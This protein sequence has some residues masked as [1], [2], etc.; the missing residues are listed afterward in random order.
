ME[1]KT[2]KQWHLKPSEFWASSESDQAYM[3]ANT[4]TE[5]LMEAWEIQQ[6]TKNLPKDK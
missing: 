2:A 1:V 4:E 3:M 6:Q 5:M